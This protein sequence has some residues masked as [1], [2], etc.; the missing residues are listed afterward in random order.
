MAQPKFKGKGKRLFP[1]PFGAEYLITSNWRTAKLNEVD[2]SGASLDGRAARPS[3]VT[4]WPQAGLRMP[5]RRTG[6]VCSETDDA[7]W[8]AITKTEADWERIRR[9]GAFHFA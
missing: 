9:G 3:F 1:A 8:L 7:I 2:F 4:S 6:V 5:R